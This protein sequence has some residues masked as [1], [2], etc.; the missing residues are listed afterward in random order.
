MLSYILTPKYKEKLEK[1]G[2]MGKPRTLYE[3]KDMLRPLHIFFDISYLISKYRT[4][5]CDDFSNTTTFHE[6]QDGAI[7]HVL[8][9]ILSKIKQ[10]VGSTKCEIKFDYE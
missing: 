6:T 1:L 3:L 9:T 4:F 2:F 7:N 5:V 8:E 10:Q